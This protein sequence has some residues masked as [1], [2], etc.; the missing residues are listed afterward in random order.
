MKFYITYFYNVRFF[1]PNMLPL[2]TAMWDP[3][4]YHDNLSQSYIFE[5]KNG[6]YNGFR[7]EE[8]NPYKIEHVSCGESCNQ[9]PGK[10]DF[11]QKYHD[12]IFSLDFNTIYQ[13]IMDL[14][15]GLKSQK[16]FRNLP[17]VCLLVHEKPANPCSERGVL[18]DWFRT[19]GIELE[20]FTK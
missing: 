18:I 20:E 3:K 14:A 9:V 7:I 11:I 13:K 19:N 6:V 5:D 2:S 10:C 1:S 17:D 12:Y 8:L 4:W 15:G 16:N